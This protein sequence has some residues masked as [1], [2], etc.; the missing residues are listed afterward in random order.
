MAPSHAGLCLCPSNQDS[1]E[2]E[3]VRASK[4]KAAQLED[5]LTPTTLDS[6]T[7]SPS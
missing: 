2:V 3:T 6:S 5:L 1:G 4:P 7:G